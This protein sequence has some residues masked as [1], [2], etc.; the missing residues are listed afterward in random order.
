MKKD[1]SH[2]NK[3]YFKNYQKEIGELGGKMNKFK[4]DNH[5]AAEDTVLDLSL[6][7]I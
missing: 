7:H 4:F 6:I 2:Y 1:L 5:I 3:E